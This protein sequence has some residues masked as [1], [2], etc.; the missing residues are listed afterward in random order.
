MDKTQFDKVLEYIETGVKEGAKAL[1]GGGRWGKKGYF[2]KPTVF[3]D[4]QDD[5]TICKE[6]IFGPVLTVFKFDDE[7]EVI[8]RA[9][10]TKYGLAG[11]LCTR[12]TGRAL[13]VASRLEAGTVWVNCYNEFDTAQPFGGYKES[14]HGRELGTAGLD[15]YSETKTVVIPIDKV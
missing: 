1:V 3:V 7:D 8:K 11:G 15:L 4:V 13:R 9:N 2:V 5:A 14:G 10:D 12:D 6:E